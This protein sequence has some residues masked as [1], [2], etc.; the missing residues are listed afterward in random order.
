[1][2]PNRYI[3]VLTAFASLAATSPASGH[4]QGSRLL[5]TPTESALRLV[6]T[7][8]ADP[9]SWVTDAGKDKLIKD[10]ISFIDITNI[11]DEEVIAMLSTPERHLSHT[12]LDQSTY[13]AQP[14]M[15]WTHENTGAQFMASPEHTTTFNAEIAMHHLKI[16]TE[17]L[18]RKRHD[19]GSNSDLER[20]FWTRDHRSVNGTRAARWLFE[21]IEKIAGANPRI[22]VTQFLHNATYQPS[23]IA[24]LPGRTSDIVVFGAHFD[25]T[26]GEPNSR[27]P[28]ADDNASGTVVLLELLRNIAERTRQNG[29]KPWTQ[30][31]NT[32]EFH[33]YAAEEAGLLGSSEIF[34]EYK[35]RNKSVVA[36][37]NHDML[38][39][40]S[41]GKITL[42]GDNIDPRL[43][44]VL[45]SIAKQHHIETLS[46]SCGY[47]C[48]DHASARNNGFP[49]AFITADRRATANKRIHTGRDTLETIQEDTLARHFKFGLAALG[50]L[51][52]A[53]VTALGRPS[54]E[55][56]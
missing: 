11:K 6:K 30:P 29:M 10:G 17:Y 13:L 45:R 26:A 53:N 34:H 48:S 44:H 18:G 50:V 4:P 35:K 5:F 40:S 52:G 12:Y 51:S 23:V 9:G 37:L 36:M 39:F 54:D 25:S 3:G 47:A 8:P 56:R 27:A 24:K 14:Q 38:G 2:N 21:T 46:F 16:M 49:A 33:F 20:R 41:T 28:G 7:S 43:T 1:M 15:E 19:L 32:V 55:P 42:G 31:R 22:E